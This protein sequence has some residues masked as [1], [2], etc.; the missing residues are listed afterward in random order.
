MELA[1]TRS[2]IKKIRKTLGL[3]RATT[4]TGMMIRTTPAL[5]NQKLSLLRKMSLLAVETMADCKLSKAA[6][7]REMVITSTNPTTQA[8]NCANRRKKAILPV[9]GLLSHAP[10][11]A[12]RSP[13]TPTSVNMMRTTTVATEVP[14]T[15][16][17]SVL[18]AKVRIQKPE[19]KKSLVKIA[20]GSM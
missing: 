1:L 7:L 12:A 10:D 8:G 14:I 11:Q 5:I 9:S 19:R 3:L 15:R 2:E 18:D 20:T 13:V 17:L 16:S 6:V 4:T